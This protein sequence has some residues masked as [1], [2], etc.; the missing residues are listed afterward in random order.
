MSEFSGLEKEAET[1]AKDHPDQVD[2]GIG[3]AAQYAER[4][5]GHKHDTE[6]EHVED[7]AFRRADVDVLLNAVALVVPPIR[8]SYLWR[9][10]LPG[11]G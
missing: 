6:I 11:R 10:V 9:P 5:T 8:L 2:K 4:E 7:A 1:Y 3:E